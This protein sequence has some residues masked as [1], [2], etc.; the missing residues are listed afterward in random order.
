MSHAYP[1]TERAPREEA[2]LS[3]AQAEARCGMTRG[4]WANAEA[5]CG[6]TRGAWANAEKAARATPAMVER[7]RAGLRQ[8]GQKYRLT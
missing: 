8:P 2:G 3:Q 5:R 7:A 1:R 6:M 4:A